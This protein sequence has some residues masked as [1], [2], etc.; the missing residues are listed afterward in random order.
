MLVPVPAPPFPPKDFA[1]L[2][3]S[4][5][6]AAAPDT[7][8][9]P[10]VPPGATSAARGGAADV[11]EVG[12]GAIVHEIPQR[13]D[14]GA[15]DDRLQPDGR[16]DRDEHAAVADRGAQNLAVSGDRI[17]S[18]VNLRQD[19]HESDRS[20]PLFELHRNP[21]DR[22]KTVSYALLWIVAQML[23]LFPVNFRRGKPIFRG[24]FCFEMAVHTKFPALRF[25]TLK[26]GC[27][28]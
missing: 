26:Q 2:S 9:V 16:N 15:D 10:V 14:G 18:V 12:N 21:G 19:H 6:Y 7:V 27:Q 11:V 5:I 23:P 20:A 8:P 3:R 4:K 22:G 24:C 25:C 28:I 1:L 13:S 17:G